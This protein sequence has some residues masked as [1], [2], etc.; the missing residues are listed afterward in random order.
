MSNMQELLMI[1]EDRVADLE[2]KLMYPD[3]GCTLGEGGRIQIRADGTKE[4]M[5]IHIQFNHPQPQ[6]VW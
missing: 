4:S 2:M 6:G 1:T 5:K 3:V